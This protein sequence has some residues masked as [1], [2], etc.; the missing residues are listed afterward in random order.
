MTGET[1]FSLAYSY[2][3]I[4]P[5]ELGV[6]SLRRDNFNSKQNMILQQRD[7]RKNDMI[8]NFESRRTNDALLDTL[9]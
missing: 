9:T 7:L 4:V 5:V 3:A 6:G 1:L 2:K 8:H